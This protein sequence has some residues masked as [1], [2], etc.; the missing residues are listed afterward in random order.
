[1]PEKVRIT[2]IVASL[3]AVMLTEPSAEHYGLDLV[4]RTGLS[5]GTIYPVLMRLRKAE[6]VEA[7]WEQIDPH[8][9]GRPARRYYRLTAHGA[10]AARTEL[11]AMFR[12][13]SIVPGITGE[14]TA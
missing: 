13:L 3:L 1:M 10:T 12:K 14:A 9:A 5:A 2:P 8:E 4:R 6:W 11:E 7:T